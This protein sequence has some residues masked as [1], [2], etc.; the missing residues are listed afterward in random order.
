MEDI[1][2]S[3]RVQLYERAV[4]PLTGGFIIAWCLWNYRFFLVLFSEL[5]LSEK[6]E[7]IDCDLYDSRQDAFYFVL[8]YPLLSTV[9][10]LFIY[11]YIARL[12]FKFVRKK[13]VEMINDKKEIDGK[14]LVDEEEFQQFKKDVHSMEEEYRKES[15]NKDKEI[16]NRNEKIES[17]RDDIKGLKEGMDKIASDRQGARDELEKLKQVN[18]TKKN[19]EVLH[20]VV[21]NGDK[22]SADKDDELSSKEEIILQIVADE[23]G[24]RVESKSV[25]ELSGFHRIKF[26]DLIERL[27]DGGYIA[28]DLHLN[29]PLNPVFFLT[30]KGRQYLLDNDLV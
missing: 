21:K 5:T 3:I 22:A 25:F 24:D 15:D 9:F 14:I 1:L 11:P 16:Q 6:I 17:L 4:S 20:K 28:S 7:W 13:Q 26:D 10:Y 12:V 27:L 30:A 2:K 8:L 29:Q 23:N 18:L 19:R